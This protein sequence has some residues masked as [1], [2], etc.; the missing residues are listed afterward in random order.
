MSTEYISKYIEFTEKGKV[1]EKTT[2][3]NSKTSVLQNAS[4]KMRR[5]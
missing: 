4:Y 3:I 2:T 5:L 1:E